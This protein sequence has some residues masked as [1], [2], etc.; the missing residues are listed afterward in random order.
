MYL[1]HKFYMFLMGLLLC[2]LPLHSKSL[3]ESIKDL[4]SFKVGQDVFD[5]INKN[6]RGSLK[7]KNIKL[8]LPNTVEIENMEALDEF[9]HRVLFS[10]RVK[11]TISLISLLTSNI[12]VSEA[13][14]SEPYFSYVIKNDIQNIVRMFEDRPSSGNRGPKPA[15]Q[16]KIPLKRLRAKMDG[17]I[18]STMRELP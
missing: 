7:A 17:L 15:S 1:K 3:G 8:T 14:V 12:R 5:S 16:T 9:G 10:P 13:F 11:L 6:I 4:F 2:A 18:C